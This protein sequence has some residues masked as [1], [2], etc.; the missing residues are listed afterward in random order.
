MAASQLLAPRPGPPASLSPS[1]HR[2][3]P[4]GRAPPDA[5]TPPYALHRRPR[6]CP[7]SSPGWYST[8]PAW[9]PDPRRT[10]ASRVLACSPS[11]RGFR[12]RSS[13][14]SPTTAPP[15]R[16]RPLQRHPER[17]LP[18]RLSPRPATGRLLVTGT[19]AATRHRHGRP[20]ASA[21]VVA[22]VLLERT[23]PHQANLPAPAS[24]T[25][26]GTSFEQPESEDAADNRPTHSPSGGRRRP[27]NL[28]S[29]YK[30]RPGSRRRRSTRRSSSCSPVAAL[31]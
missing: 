31:S 5:P 27:R 12:S 3:H 23:L 21:I 18:G 22:F 28:R 26:S 11:V 25:P 14:V 29:T 10:P 16:A 6:S 30:Q 4:T 24:A 19:G 8:P 7:G 13:P 9:S 2:R 1:P 17:H 20:A 15:G